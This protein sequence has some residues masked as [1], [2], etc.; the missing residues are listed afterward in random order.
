MTSN[1]VFPGQH[2]APSLGERIRPPEA[3]LRR[4]SPETTTWFCKDGVLTGERG[5]VLGHGWSGTEHLT[6]EADENEGTYGASEKNKEVRGER[7]TAM[8]EEKGIVPIIIKHETEA[9]FL[10]HEITFRNAKHDDYTK[11]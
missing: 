9:S 4:K 5:V 8:A 1:P 2:L 10:G 11:D 7:Y 3:I 6:F